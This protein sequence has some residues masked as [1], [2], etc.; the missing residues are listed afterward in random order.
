MVAQPLQFAL[1]S[2]LFN[3]NLIKLTPQLTGLVAVLFVCW[4]P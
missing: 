3:Q 2:L 1:R 4:F